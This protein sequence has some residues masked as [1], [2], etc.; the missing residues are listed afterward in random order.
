MD[1]ELDFESDSDFEFKG[2]RTLALPPWWLIWVELKLRT[3]PA[4]V[5]TWI[6]I[7]IWLRSLRGWGIK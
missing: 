3:Q 5:L 4:L 6:S 7:M 2:D 1:D